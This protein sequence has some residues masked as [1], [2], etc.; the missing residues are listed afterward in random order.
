MYQNK[1]T[2]NSI[3]KCVFLRENYYLL[4]QGSLIYVPKDQIDNDQYTDNDLGPIKRY[5]KITMAFV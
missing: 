4:I 1:H 3:F 5:T 2:T